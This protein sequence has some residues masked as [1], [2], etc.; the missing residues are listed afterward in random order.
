VL[1]DFKCFANVTKVISCGRI[2]DC[3]AAS[4]QRMSDDAVIYEGND[5]RPMMEHF[6]DEIGQ[7]WTNQS[8]FRGNWNVKDN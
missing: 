4:M 1:G 7:G 2:V 8:L 3:A 5:K 6:G